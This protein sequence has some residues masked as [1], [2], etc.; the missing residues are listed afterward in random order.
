MPDG[1]WD[2]ATVIPTTKDTAI[3]SWSKSV[4]AITDKTNAKVHVTTDQHSGALLQNVHHF[5][6][7]FVEE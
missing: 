6:G 4:S 7:S 2:L 1:T 3:W 5:L